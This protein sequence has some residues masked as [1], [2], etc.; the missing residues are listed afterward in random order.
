[1]NVDGDAMPE[2]CCSPRIIERC[3]TC[4]HRDQL[5]DIISMIYQCRS[6]S[7]NYLTRIAL[8]NIFNAR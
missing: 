7:E 6:D 3:L 1:M 8:Q 5:D 4:L 2:L